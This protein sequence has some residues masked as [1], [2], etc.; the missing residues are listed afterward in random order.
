MALD[1]SAI[2]ADNDGMDY[3]FEKIN[4]ALHLL[5]GRLRLN[6]S[7]IFTI[8]VCGGTALNAMQLISRTT[9]DVDIVALMD[10]NNQLTD[11]APLPQELLFAAREVADTLKLPLDWFNNGPSSGDGGLFRMGLPNGFKER[12]I[13][14]NQGQKL[15]IYMISRVDQIHFKLYAAIDQFGGYHASDLKQLGP[16]DDELLEAVRWAIT[17]DPS[18]GFQQAAKLF[19]REFGY[20]RLVD[21]I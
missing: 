8:V 2:I 7:G 10:S 4:E 21:Q 3:G 13:K 5:D 12:L 14:K 19:L 1:I 16:S 17:H 15:T 20:G 11:P 6:G 9:K 18:E